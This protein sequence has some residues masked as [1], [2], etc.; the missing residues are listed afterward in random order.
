MRRLD[1][2]AEARR[3][4]LV[5][6]L[7]G[8][9]A[10]ADQLLV[11]L[12][13]R[14]PTDDRASG[15]RESGAGGGRR[16][17]ASA[18]LEC[19]QPLLEN[20]VHIQGAVAARLVDEHGSVEVG[21]PPLVAEL[22]SVP[23]PSS[24]ELASVRTV[25]GKRYLGVRVTDGTLDLTVLFDHAYADPIFSSR[26]GVGDAGE[27]FLADAQGYFVTPG[28][29]ASSEGHT[30]PIDARPMVA[31][32]QGRAGSMIA[33]DYRHVIVIHGFQP[34]PEIGGGCIMA[35][36]DHAEAFAPVRA[37]GR[38]L[39]GITVGGLVFAIVGSVLVARRLTAPLARLEAC[40]QALAAGDLDSP[41]PV[42]GPA[43]HRAYARAFADMARSLRRRVTELDQARAELDAFNASVTHDLRAPLRA[44]AGFGAAI[45]ADE[46][47]ILSPVSADML[48][49]V[50]LA[51]HR[52][53]NL[54][55]DL[56]VL[57]QV[58]RSGMTRVPVD[59]SHLAH[60]V[61]AELRA[62][63]AG[64]TVELDVAPGLV[65]E[66][67][68]GL[69]QIVLA[70]LLGNAWKFTAK[71]AEPRVEVFETVVNGE[72]AFAVRDNG[73]GFDPGYADRLFQPFSRLHGTQEFEGTGIGLA[74]VARIVRRH[75]GRV[76]A[77][78]TPGHGAT[79][80][81]TLPNVAS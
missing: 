50:L 47:N 44:I 29:Y 57:S 17:D 63:D 28:R 14:C 51:S 25:A 37:Y 3:E 41:V 76:W 5:Q 66:G 40:V 26:T 16:G 20:F 70:N 54:I 80:Y 38:T 60:A 23:I 74:T 71:T 78:G 58:S 34:V 4:A 46:T 45:L 8:T 6:K 31:C 75:G 30:H 53:Q 61:A 73:V 24:P 68:P 59:L 77:E 21:T 12:A 65:A 27:S 42:E 48:R 62:S 39:A 69:L 43:E 52:M 72:R 79:F 19:R 1:V 18:R 56:L 7:Q 9:Q 13:Q 15:G 33:P 22:G 67:D 55:D 64:R 49:R 11:T 10:R 81:F 36:M 32:L 35:H 2:V